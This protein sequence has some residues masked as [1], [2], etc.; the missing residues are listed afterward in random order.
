M[1]IDKTT[2]Q[3][4]MVDKYYVFKE[5]LKA[6]CCSKVF[7]PGE[8]VLVHM[9]TSKNRLLIKD[10]KGGYHK[11]KRSSLNRTAVEYKTNK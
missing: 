8:I 9:Y 11:V 1:Y 2:E 5:K 10:K 6:R 3:G 4:D 7:K